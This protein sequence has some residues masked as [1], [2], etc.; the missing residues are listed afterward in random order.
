MTSIAVTGIEETIREVVEERL[1]AIT[2]RAAWLNVSGAAKYLDTT[3]D[4]IRSLV[5]R[6]AIPVHR[7]PTGRLLFRPEEL[8]AWVDEPRLDA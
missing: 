7:T 3:E 6:N 1:A 2:V 5:K 8:D 4:S